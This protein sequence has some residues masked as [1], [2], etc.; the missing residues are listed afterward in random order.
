MVLEEKRRLA[1]IRPPPL[2]ASGQACPLA[3]GKF[4]VR[5]N[6]KIPVESRAVVVFLVCGRVVLWRAW[7][8]EQLCLVNQ[9]RSSEAVIRQKIK[10]KGKSNPV[11]DG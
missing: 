1:V 8:P 2:W 10:G 9:E 11:D 6:W 3:P 5:R 7:V 4:H